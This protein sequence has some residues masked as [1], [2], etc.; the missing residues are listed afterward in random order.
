MCHAL[1]ITEKNAEAELARMT[2]TG[3]VMAT[4]GPGGRS[5][6]FDRRSPEVAAVDAI[7]SAYASRRIAVVNFVASNALNRMRAFA[8]AFRLRRGKNE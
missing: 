8:D 6:A 3:V 4:S 7:A 5:F 1:G 2:A